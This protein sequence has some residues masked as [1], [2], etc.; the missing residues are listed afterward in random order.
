MAPET[1]WYATTSICRGWYDA[2]SLI[3]NVVLPQPYHH[4]TLEGHFV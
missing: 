4:T 2:M 1:W 3:Q